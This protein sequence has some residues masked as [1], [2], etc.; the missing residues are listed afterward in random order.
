MTQLVLSRSHERIIEDIFVINFAGVRNI[1]ATDCIRVPTLQTFAS[2][3]SLVLHDFQPIDGFAKS[4][5]IIHRFP[6]C[7]YCRLDRSIVRQCTFISIDDILFSSTC[8]TRLEHLKEKFN[9]D[10]TK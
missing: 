10:Q 8:F 9:L 6:C 1:S 7:V 2:V 3:D 4:S 5:R